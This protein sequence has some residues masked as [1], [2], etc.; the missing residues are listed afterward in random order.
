[1][2]V[3]RPY[4][5]GGHTSLFVYLGCVALLIAFFIADMVVPLGYAVGVLYI[6]VI[7]LSLQSA[8]KKCMLEM[9]VIST[10]LIL[11]GFFLSPGGGDI[12]KGMFNRAIAVFAIWT[13]ALISYRRKILEE[14]RE[15]AIKEREKALDELKVLRGLIPICASCKKIRN[16]EGYWI[17][18]EA[19][20]RDHSEANFSHGICPECSR[21]LYP[22]FQPKD[23]GPDPKN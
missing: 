8:R 16:D 4:K 18:M 1:M 19:Y 5:K 23:H 22:D 13:T 11:F 3:G 15:N 20:I 2:S 9:A 12:F 10:M 7:L 21:K 14:K 6:L 17:Q